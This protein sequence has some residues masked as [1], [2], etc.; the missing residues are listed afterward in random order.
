MEAKDQARLL[1]DEASRLRQQLRETSDRL[2]AVDAEIVE[3]QRVAKRAER[4]RPT[5]SSRDVT[6]DLDPTRRLVE[7]G[8]RQPL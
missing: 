3:L 4:Q 5:A 7:T 8:D 1:K 2:K 6:P